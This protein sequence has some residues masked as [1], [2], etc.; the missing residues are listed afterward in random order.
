MFVFINYVYNSK[1]M[2]Y[3][4]RV[5]DFLLLFISFIIEVWLCTCC[6]VPLFTCSFEAGFIPGFEYFV[7]FF[8]GSMLT[9]SGGM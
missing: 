3:G 7:A 9:T 8:L 6:G 5:I 1:G 2:K 4:S